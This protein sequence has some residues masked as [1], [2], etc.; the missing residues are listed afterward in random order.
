MSKRDYYDILGV[1]RGADE[2][3]LK[4][5]YRKLAL[6]Y[7]PDQNA[8]DEEAEA[9]FK[10]IGEAY[11]ILS[12]AEKRAAYDRF[13]HSAF[14]GGGSP[15]GNPFGGGNPHDIFDD[16]FSQVFGGAT[17]N[18]RQQRGAQAGSDLRYDMSVTLEDTYLGKETKITIPTLGACGKC[19]GSGA[20]PGSRAETCAGCG[21]AGRI[22]RS[23]GF[24]TME[25]TC[26][27]CKGK[28]TRIASPCNNCH[29][30]GQERKNKSLSVKIPSGVEA[31]MRIRLAG[32][33]EAGE[34]GG[35][36]GDLYIFIDVKEHDLFER[37][38]SNLYCLTPVPMTTAALGGDIEVP[39]IDG[40]RSRVTIAEGT[41]TGKKLRL[42]G[43]GMPA[44]RGN[45]YGDLYIEVLVETPRNLNRKQK[46]L[47]RQLCDGMG[48]DCNPE[49]TSFLGRVKKF[50][51]GF[52]D[53]DANTHV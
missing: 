10:E 15:G 23:Q 17:Q 49:S 46:D 27:N 21:G 6:K 45:T 8:G 16:L 20:K 44:L 5:A 7:H 53:K 1:E 34:R 3:K 38:G 18:R 9:M 51:D 40:G 50:V 14:E 41:Q 33:G 30:S 25:Q 43:K 28:G 29:G 19:K 39:T 31:G 26:P 11:A 36:R 2:K 32:E 52:A 37:D 24:F 35:P 48:E 22:R 13:G 47:L 4:S 42:K 12:D